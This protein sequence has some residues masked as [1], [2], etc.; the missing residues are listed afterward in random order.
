MQGQPVPCANCG[1]MATPLPD[2]RTYKCTYCGTQVL[3]AIE[4]HQIAAGMRLDLQ[5][6]DAFLSQ[7]ANTLSVGFAENTRINAN[8]RYVL[9]IEVDVEPD[10]FIAQRAG[11]QVVTQHKKMVRGIALR[12][13]TLPIDYWFELLTHGLARHANKNIRAAWVLGKLTG[14]G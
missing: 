2:G 10:V 13:Q 12:T 6:A 4:G 8:G 5:N 1:A 9:A 14:K 3:V 7:L 11:N